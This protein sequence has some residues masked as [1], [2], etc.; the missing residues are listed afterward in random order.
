MAL[1]R[2]QTLSRPDVVVQH[3]RDVRSVP[4]SDQVHR[5][6]NAPLFDHLVGEGEQHWRHR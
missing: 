6:E 2:C 3:G 5:S 1:N 4:D